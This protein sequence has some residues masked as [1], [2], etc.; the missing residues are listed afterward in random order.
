MAAS[1]N[2]PEGLISPRFETV[3]D[4]NRARPAGFRP[5]SRDG[6]THIK[7]CACGDGLATGYFEASHGITPAVAGRSRENLPARSTSAVH[8]CDL[9]A[10][11]QLFHHLIGAAIEEMHLSIH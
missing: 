11:A 3:S 10:P 9:T 6:T 5:Q 4:C 8:A 7:G 2:K 1:K